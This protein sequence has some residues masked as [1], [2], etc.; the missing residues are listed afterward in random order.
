M[1]LRL[2]WGKGR[3]TLQCSGPNNGAAIHKS[4]A[5]SLTKELHGDVPL[6]YLVAFSIVVPAEGVESSHLHPAAAQLLAG[7]V[8]E[9]ADVGSDLQRMT[10]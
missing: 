8:K 9:S 6:H 5:D 1:A 10:G 7:V 2:C 3:Y 4:G